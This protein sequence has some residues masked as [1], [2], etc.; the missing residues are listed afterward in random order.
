[1]S[2]AK[3]EQGLKYMKSARFYWFAGIAFA[4]GCTAIGSSQYAERFGTPEPRE[5]VVERLPA[6]DVDYWRDVRPIVENR[7]VVCHAC[8]DAPCQL[9]MSS[10]EGIERGAITSNSY[11][12]WLIEHTWA[13]VPV[14]GKVGEFLATFK[15]YPPRA[16]AASFTIGDALEKLEDGHGG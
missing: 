7:C 10:I 14:Q 3:F 15:E 13:L 6:G 16:K 12:N 2:L 4:A 8:Y 11:N 5:R 1:L 9:K